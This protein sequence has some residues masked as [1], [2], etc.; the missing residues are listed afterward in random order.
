MPK[1]RR[2]IPIQW[3]LN[4]YCQSGKIDVSCQGHRPIFFK[5]VQLL[6]C[7]ILVKIQWALPTVGQ[8]HFILLPPPKTHLFIFIKF[9]EADLL[10]QNGVNPSGKQKHF[11][12]LIHRLFSIR[13]F[14]SCH[15]VRKNSKHAYC[16][17]DHFK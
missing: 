14:K 1:R 12:S 7:K 3:G 5:N 17:P 9:T 11:M 10:K 6:T 4:R 2:L 15:K 13:N 16:M 8:W